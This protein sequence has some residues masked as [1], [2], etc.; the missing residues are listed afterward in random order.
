LRGLSLVNPAWRLELALRNRLA[1]KSRVAFGPI[2]TGERTLGTRKFH[3]DPIV[4]FINRHSDEYVCGVF[5]EGVPARRLFHYDIVVIVKSFDFA[6]PDLLRILT[7]RGIRLIYSI[8]DNPAGSIRSYRDEPWFL[9][10]MDGL[11]LSSPLQVEDVSGVDAARAAIPPPVIARLHKDDYAARGPIT[12]IW[13]GWV[14]NLG[15]M[16]PVNA[17]VRR[18]AQDCNQPVELFYYSNLPRRSDGIVQYAPWE[19]SKWEE[20]LVGADV[21]IVVKPP[22]DPIQRRKPPTKVQNFMAAGL[23]VVCT[24]SA[25][26]RDVIDDGRTGFFAHSEQDW[27]D[28]LRALVEDAPLRER[29]GRAARE[30]VLA[31]ANLER[32]ADLHV[33][34]FRAVLARPAPRPAPASTGTI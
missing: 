28:R 22:A 14:E 11:I 27:Y 20:R 6:T 23:P 29:V 26:D 4:R 30:S 21:A 8:V 32:V 16:E 10:S 33:D 1:G 13:E 24:P 7:E 31:T 3:I 19:L 5:L 25:A 15:F 18:V 17:I 9:E 12:I 34:L 2:L